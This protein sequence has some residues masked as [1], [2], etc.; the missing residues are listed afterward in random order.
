[1]YRGMLLHGLGFRVSALKCSRYIMGKHVI[2]PT[3]EFIMDM[4]EV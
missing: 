3:K 2:L 1:M 4:F